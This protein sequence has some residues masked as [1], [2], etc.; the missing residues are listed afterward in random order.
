MS[1]FVEVNR[2]PTNEGVVGACG[3]GDI[4]YRTAN[5][6]NTRTRIKVCIQKQ[7]IHMHSAHIWESLV[8]N[9][10]QVQ[11]ADRGNMHLGVGVCDMEN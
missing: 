3:F 2:V 5:I 4:W 7:Y 8:N 9:Q 6:T 11:L 1:F 10:Q